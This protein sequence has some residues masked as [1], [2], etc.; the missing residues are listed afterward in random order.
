MTAILAVPAVL[1]GDGGLG[2]LGVN[3]ISIALVSAAVAAVVSRKGDANKAWFITGWTDGQQLPS[4]RPVIPTAFC[5]SGMFTAVHLTAVPIFSSKSD[6]CESSAMSTGFSSEL[7][8]FA[9]NS[10]FHAVFE[11]LQN[12]FMHL[13]SQ[14]FSNNHA[15]PLVS[16]ITGALLSGSMILFVRKPQVGQSDRDHSAEVSTVR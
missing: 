10:R 8:Q 5:G 14:I 16:P 12:R 1:D 2:A 3:I 13:S 7:P 9:G 11:G 4:F 15:L 6:T